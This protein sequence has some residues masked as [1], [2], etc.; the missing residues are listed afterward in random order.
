MH[1]YPQLSKTD[2]LELTQ[3]QVSYLIEMGGAV[4]NPSVLDK[5]KKMAFNGKLDF[6]HYII[7]KFKFI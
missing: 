2:V 4:N 3:S 6:E 1:Y 5:Y 7:D